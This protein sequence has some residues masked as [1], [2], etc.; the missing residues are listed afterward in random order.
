MKMNNRAIEFNKHIMNM[1]KQERLS[2][3]IEIIKLEI[4]NK[5]EVVQGLGYH[6]EFGN[7]LTIE[8]LQGRQYML[9]N[10]T[11]ELEKM[12]AIDDLPF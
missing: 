4:K 6:F 9:G 8:E 10:L 11:R 7:D 12:Y 3:K 1:T 5:K 2:A